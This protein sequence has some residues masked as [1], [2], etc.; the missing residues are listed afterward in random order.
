MVKCPHNYIHLFKYARFCFKIYSKQSYSTS[1]PFPFILLSSSFSMSFLRQ[2]PQVLFPFHG[3]NLPSFLLFIQLEAKEA[4]SYEQVFVSADERVSP[5]KYIVISL[6]FA[7]KDS[8]GASVEVD[9]CTA[10][11]LCRL[12]F[13]CVCR[14]KATRWHFKKTR[15]PH[16]P[17]REVVRN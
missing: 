11:H 1:T 2:T 8:F 3:A 4:S 15:L 6:V 10:Q 17:N 16:V 5:E 13:N 7:Y 9:A 12:S 14:A